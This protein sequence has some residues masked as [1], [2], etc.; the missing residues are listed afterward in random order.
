M[1]N[2]GSFTLPFLF[3]NLKMFLRQH[4]IIIVVRLRRQI[5][6][7][8]A[9][10]AARPAPLGRT[11]SDFVSASDCTNLTQAGCRSVFRR[12]RIMRSRKICARIMRFAQNAMAKNMQARC[13]Q[14]RKA[15]F[16]RCCPRNIMRNI[17]EIIPY[18]LPLI[19]L[20]PRLLPPQLL[21]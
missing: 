6:S 13:V 8:F 1:K 16:A 10:C 18:Y 5:Y 14:S 11:P 7:A 12:R 4:S 17:M 9:F 20:L 2:Y 21:R 3:Y 19:P 15:F